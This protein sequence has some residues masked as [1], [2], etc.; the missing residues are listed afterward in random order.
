MFL[1]SMEIQGYRGFQQKREIKFAIP[2]QD[3]VTEGSGLTINYWFE[4]CWKIINY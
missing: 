3:S 4:Q 1:Q 2:R